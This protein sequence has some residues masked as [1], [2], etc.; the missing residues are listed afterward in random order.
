MMLLLLSPL[1]QISITLEVE[2]IG[3]TKTFLYIPVSEVLRA[4]VDCDWSLS[5]RRV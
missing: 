5:S 2:N 1:S 4:R 3:A